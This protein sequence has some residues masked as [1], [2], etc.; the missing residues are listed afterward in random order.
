MGNLETFELIL[1]L[2]KNKLFIFNLKYKC[3]NHQ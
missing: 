1:S 2:D 3:F